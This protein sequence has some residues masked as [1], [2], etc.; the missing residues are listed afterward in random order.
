M[1]QRVGD[2]FLSRDRRARP[3]HG[4]RSPQGASGLRVCVGDAMRSELFPIWP[5]RISGFLCVIRAFLV[6][7][8]KRSAAMRCVQHGETSR[9]DLVAWRE[10][11]LS[12]AQYCLGGSDGVA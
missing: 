2:M 1:D 3:G 10:I 9:S 11:G 8:P 4:Q 12:E 7:E 5:S 6:L